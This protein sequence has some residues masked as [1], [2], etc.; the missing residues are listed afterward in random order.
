MYI[1]SI[2]YTM[3]TIYNRK[4]YLSIQKNEILKYDH[5]DEQKKT[6]CLSERVRHKSHT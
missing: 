6:L 5:L 2:L 4:Y 3:Y 1:Y